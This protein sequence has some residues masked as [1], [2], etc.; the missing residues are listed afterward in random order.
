MNNQVPARL[1]DSSLLQPIQPIRPV[2]YH[3]PALLDVF[4]MVVGRAH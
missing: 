4:G 2:L 1:F 3:A